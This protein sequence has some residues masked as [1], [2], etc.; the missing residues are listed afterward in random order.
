MKIHGTAKGGALSK[1]DFG[2]A[3]GGGA[4]PE[5][6][7][8]QDTG[9]TSDGFG[10]NNFLGNKIG[11]GNSVIGESIT[12]VQFY[13]SK[14][15]SPGPSGIMRAVVY[16]GDFDGGSP[17]KVHTFQTITLP[18]DLTGS[19][20][21]TTFEGDSYTVEEN[22]A[23]GIECVFSGG[24]SGV[25]CYENNSL[26]DAEWLMIEYNATSWSENTGRSMRMCVIG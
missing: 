20:V 13:M 9:T 6:S 1:K 23:I 22:D 8:C 21:L 10:N 19:K 2:V 14:Y 15:G 17:T 11:S 5:T 7:Y 26:T 3:F 18:A 12:K 16:Q 25:A 24:T 4:V